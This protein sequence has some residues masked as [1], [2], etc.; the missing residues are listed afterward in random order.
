MAIEVRPCASREELRGALNAISHYFGHEQTEEEVDR[1]AEWIDGERMHAAFDDG[2]VVGGAGA[3]SYRMSV[4]GGDVPAAGV[5][6]VG[7]LP[8]HRRRGVLTQLMRAQLDDSQARGDVA[9]FLWASEAT[10]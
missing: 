3:F 10:I 7:V 9:A 6:V 4:P 5:T 1:F 8:T 2:R